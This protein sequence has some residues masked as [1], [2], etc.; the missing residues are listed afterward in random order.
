MSQAEAL[1]VLLEQA[2]DVHNNSCASIP[3]EGM[4][5]P[6]P[7]DCEVPALIVM[8]AESA[9]R[10]DR[11]VLVDILIYHTRRDIKGCRCGWAE[12]GRS[13]PEHVATVYEEAVNAKA[14][15]E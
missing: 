6:F 11:D 15:A 10:Y 4:N 8:W 9:L 13:W 5:G 7:C 14:E 12:L 2:H 1:K 3:Q